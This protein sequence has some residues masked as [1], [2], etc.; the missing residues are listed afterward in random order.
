MAME[1]TP[2]DG[3]ADVGD[4]SELHED[5]DGGL[6]N[7]EEGDTQRFEAEEL[8]QR[9]EIAD[10]ELAEVKAAELEQ[11]RH[12]QQAETEQ[13]QEAEQREAS[14]QQH[15][16]TERQQETDRQQQVAQAQ[17]HSLMRHA[18]QKR[19]TDRES[20]RQRQQLEREQ[21]VQAEQAEQ[22][23]IE[24]EQ[25]HQQQR[26][27]Q[28]YRSEQQ[29]TQQQETAHT[30]QLQQTQT[31][32]AVGAAQPVE[33]A[34][35]DR[36]AANNA[37]DRVTRHELE[38][39]AETA[40]ASERSAATVARAAECSAAEAA[41]AD[42]RSA[43]EASS[44]RGTK[45]HAA[46][47]SPLQEQAPKK[48]KG[49]SEADDRK[50]RPSPSPETAEEVSVGARVKAIETT[51]ATR[52]RKTISPVASQA[53]PVM[54]RGSKKSRGVEV[55]PDLNK[56][57]TIGARE[58]LLHYVPSI[59]A[60]VKQKL[61]AREWSVSHFNEANE[62]GSY[63]Q[64][65]KF[66]AEAPPDVLSELSL[67]SMTEQVDGETEDAARTRL[68][69]APDEEAVQAALVGL[70]QLEAGKSDWDWSKLAGLRHMEA[71]CNTPDR[72]LKAA[73]AVIGKLFAIVDGVMQELS[74]LAST[75]WCAT[76]GD[77]IY[78]AGQ[79]SE[80]CRVRAHAVIFGVMSGNRTTALL[81][82]ESLALTMTDAKETWSEFSAQG[83]VR[84]KIG[85][86]VQMDAF[87][88][89]QAVVDAIS[90]EASYDDATDP[91]RRLTSTTHFLRSTAGRLS[92]AK[93]GAWLDAGVRR[94]LMGVL[95]S[96]FDVDTFCTLV[97]GEWENPSDACIAMAEAL[98][99]WKETQEGGW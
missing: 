20:E 39:A 84:S 87:T 12:Q 66:I 5:M 86:Q 28:P 76:L 63:P 33:A 53:S 64:M 91:A 88:D 46:N 68:D 93:Y 74:S 83:E 50:R 80:S 21:L 98:E 60:A 24:V 17:Q 57:A 55:W 6:Q 65:C 41:Q 96:Q 59:Q 89:A 95:N 69:L 35:D 36:Q 99:V 70:A 11:Q 94:Q 44:P 3:N 14:I 40:L 51:G 18:A 49:V 26:L 73:V 48:T 56:H 37:L 78:K 62:S 52:T 16:E 30:Q 54:T 75:A 15:A 72:A 1:D 7:T 82:A 42:E 77:W 19:N 97:E 34:M 67:I 23:R 90:P 47:R 13:Q 2:A 32:G 81:V 22:Q 10:R 4:G 61:S 29:H 38:E 8:A 27:A 58:Q 92:F 31:D 43:E 9:R 25:S 79:G 45:M 85:A 71:R